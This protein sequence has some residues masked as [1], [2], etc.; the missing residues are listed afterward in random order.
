MVCLDAAAA[1]CCATVSVASFV[2]PPPSTGYW[3]QFFDNVTHTAEDVF[4]ALKAYHAAL[5]L[6][7]SSYQMDPWW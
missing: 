3:P 5:G 4:L 6:S 7:L 2:T 1:R